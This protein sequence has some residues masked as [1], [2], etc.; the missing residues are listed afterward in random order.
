MND[1][2]KYFTAAI[3]DNTPYKNKKLMLERDKSSNQ[4]KKK[5]ILLAVEQDIH[6]VQ[7]LEAPFLFIS[8][9]RN[10]KCIIQCKWFIVRLKV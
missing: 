8:I 9:L 5:S 10:I 1:D 2:Q 7:K 3:N 4:S 6:I